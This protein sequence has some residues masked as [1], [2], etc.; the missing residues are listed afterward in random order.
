[1]K[2]KLSRSLVVL[3]VLGICVYA[4]YPTI[5]WYFLMTDGEKELLDK[6]PEEKAKTKNR[7]ML[8]IDELK[9][10][11]PLTYHQIKKDEDGKD[12]VFDIRPKQELVALYKLNPSEA[13][14]QTIFGNQTRKKKKYIRLSNEAIKIQKEIKGAQEFTD[15]RHKIIKLGLDLNGGTHLSVSVDKHDLIK[16]LQKRYEQKGLIDENSIEAIVREKGI[17]DESK[18]KFDEAYLI[19]EIKKKNK[20]IK[21]SDLQK[22]LEKRKNKLLTDDVE[23]YPN[24]VKTELQKA[25][26][27]AITVIRNRIDKFGVS[28]VNLSRGLGDTIFIELPGLDKKSVEITKRT[29]TEAGVL[30]FRVVNKKIFNRSGTK[31]NLIPFEY[32]VTR[33]E[34]RGYFS[35][36][37][38]KDPISGQPTD[39]LASEEIRKRME[40][41]G[42]VLSSKADGTML[43]P[44]YTSDEFG[45]KNLAAYTLLK[46]RIEVEGSLLS[47]ASVGYDKNGKPEV[48][49]AFNSEGAVKFAATTRNNI[50]YQMAVIL[51]GKVMSDP[52]INSEIKGRGVITLG[53]KNRKQMQEEA[54]QLVA[55]LKAGVLPAKLIISSA[56]TIGPSLGEENKKAGLFAIIIGLGIVIIFMLY[57]YRLPGFVAVIA[58]FLN[59][60]LLFAVLSNFGSALTLPGI[61]GIILTIG[62]AVDANVIIFER[63]REEIHAGKIHHALIDGAYEKA[64]SAIFDSNL[65][66]IL[67]A[68]ILSNIGSGIIKGFGTTLMW[69]IICSMFTALFVTRIIFD[70][71]TDYLDQLKIVILSVSWLFVLVGL[72]IAF[73]SAAGFVA[74]LSGSDS[75]YQEIVAIIPIKGYL[76]AISLYIIMAIGALSFIG[77]GLGFIWS[78]KYK[79]VITLDLPFVITKWFGA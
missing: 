35:P 39:Q 58:L 17:P 21:P 30:V 69:G 68:F 24:K 74:H 44:I 36:R 49:F 23:G 27:N 6:T 37:F 40:E 75:V 25:R 50:N 53:G 38:V 66:T 56:I 48:Q 57:Y 78:I 7:F 76:K 29:I 73:L 9:K 11:V 70:F 52:V 33:G 3:A 14:A 77:I 59:L 43:Y 72:G 8:K 13:A 71:L 19:K 55:V 20:D 46:N 51:D 26:D 12:L 41:A 18:I 31:V 28:E 64:F 45:N 2:N 16:K 32:Q 34:H 61:A 47:D 54:E 42:I 79:R 60:F 65:T 62:M 67:A 10:L 22:K 15:L 1:M 5:S 63:M 4:I